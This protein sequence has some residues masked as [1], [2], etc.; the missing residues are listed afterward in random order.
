MDSR[1]SGKGVSPWHTTP[2]KAVVGFLLA[3]FFVFT[4][5]AF[6]ADIMDMGREPPFR[7]GVSVLLSGLFAVCYAITGITLRGQFWKGVLPLCA[8]QVVVMGLLARYFPDAP[9][10]VQT[11]AAAMGRL[12]ARLIFDGVATIVAVS[13][14]YV[15]FLFVSISES[16]RH[17]RA[18]AE[19][20][21]L[22][23]EMAAARAV[24]QMILPEQTESFPGYADDSVNRP[25]KKV[26]GRTGEG[27]GGEDRV[28][29]R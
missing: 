28:L 18:N 14:G 21:A 8:L 19:K 23:A 20:A 3:V 27:R 5:I 25:A 6:A 17:I 10:P 26:A 24:Q 22:E 29:S 2:P 7:F 9:Q 4:T 13:L 11:D 1:D 16:R 15:G 12:H